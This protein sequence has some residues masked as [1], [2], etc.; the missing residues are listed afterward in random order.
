[1]RDFMFRP[2]RFKH[3]ML[4]ITLISL[5]ESYNFFINMYKIDLEQ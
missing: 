1:M 3:N 2:I 4:M 5:C